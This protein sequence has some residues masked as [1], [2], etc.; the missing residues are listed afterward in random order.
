[1]DVRCMYSNMIFN[2]SVFDV[3]RSTRQKSDISDI[4]RIRKKLSPHRN[5]LKFIYI[6]K[7]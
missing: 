3:I 1:M 7:Y 2:I 5:H 6:S 4:I